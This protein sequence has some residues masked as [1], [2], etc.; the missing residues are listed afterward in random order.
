MM[1]FLTPQTQKNAWK[2]KGESPPAQE[3][4]F[5]FLRAPAI[6][7]PPETLEQVIE[8]GNDYFTRCADN[9]IIPTLT[10]LTLAL[11]L[12]TVSSIHRI[13][14][15]HPDF[16]FPLGR[17]LTAIAYHYEQ[18]MASGK[19]KYAVSQF[20]LKHL[21]FF[22]DDHE[23]ALP[24]KF[25]SDKQEV[26]IK[27]YEEKREERRLPPQE[28]YEAMLAGEDVDVIEADYVEVPKDEDNQ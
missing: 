1:G 10:G 21:N 6:G 25:W 15:Y 20:M 7:Y 19:V 14:K 23:D 16:R 24:A 26:E 5:S 3:D 4:I 17:C 28:A 27:I 8:R 13:A 2:D 22:D 9:E 12:P 18:G 11:G